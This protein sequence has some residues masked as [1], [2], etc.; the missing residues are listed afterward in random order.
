MKLLLSTVKTDCFDSKLALKNMYN[1]VGNAPLEV[2]LKEFEL[3]EDDQRIYEEL[4]DK[5]YSILYFHADEINESKIVHICE[6]IKKA[7]PSCITIIGGKEVSFETREFMLAHP[8]VDYVFRGEGEKVLFDFVRSIITY[9]FNFESIDG[10]AYREN[11]EILVNKIGEPIRYEDIPFAYDKFEVQEGETVYYESSRG[12]PDTCHYS[13]YMPGVSLRSL[14]LNRICNELRYFLVKKACRVEFV[15]KWF[16]YDVSR[17]YR[18]W[19]YL[20]NNDNG[21]TSF[22]FDVNGDLLDEETVEL[23][24]EAREGL[25]HF[26]I[27]IE[28]TNAVALAAAGRKENIYQL[29]YNVSKLL[30]N[31]K[32]N[33][34]VIQRVGL[35]GETIELFERSFNKIYNLGADE[36]DIEVLRIKK[37][38]MFRQKADE[39]GYEY[40]REYPNE[41]ITNDYISAANI[42]RIKL[43][44]ETVKRFEHGFE[45]SIGKILFDAGMKPFAFFDGLTSFIMENDLTCKLGK[46][47]NLYRV[48]YTYAAEI[49]DKNEDTLKLQV[50]QEVLHSDMN[51]NVSQD[52]IRRLERKGWE[53]HVKAKS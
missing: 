44:A 26:N 14:S 16:N 25:F 40:S 32:V 52:V 11:D 19:E 35:P 17:A 50:L 10:L 15:E 12:V 2:T 18:I 4:L 22:S 43:V 3:S 47:E 33:V 20:I 48:L 13:Q 5:K 51:N 27:D 34:R 21:F 29:M 42:V 49:Y 8:E 39:F 1:V 37:G 45:D 28:S 46:E 38:T 6:M 30:Q 41:V 9:S 31:S 24:S 23:L 36:F 7:I 53:I